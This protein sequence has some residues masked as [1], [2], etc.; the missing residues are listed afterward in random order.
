MGFREGNLN[1]YEPYDAASQL[2]GNQRVLVPIER[3]RTDEQ[4]G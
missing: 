1:A 2:R 4:L 3:T